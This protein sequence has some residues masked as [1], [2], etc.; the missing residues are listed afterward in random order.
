M[1][2]EKKQTQ[3]GVV[4]LVPELRFPEFQNDGNWVEK[5]LGQIGEPQMC[6]RVFKEQ[7]TSN[8]VNGIPFY[9]IGT[10]GKIP[11]SYI[12]V[13]LYE[14]FKSTYNFPNKGDILISASGT[15]GRLVIYDGKPAYFQDSNIVWLGHSGSEI[16]NELLYYCYSILNWQT[17]DGGVIKRLYNSDLKAISIKFPKN[18]SEQQKIASCL[19]SLDELIAA[20]NEKLEALKD[21][22]KGLM[23]NLFPQEGGT[24]PKLRF[25]EFENDGEWVVKKLGDKRVSS[26]INDKIESNVLTLDNYVSTDNMLPNYSGITKASK[27]ALNSKATKFIKGDIL[28]SN[29][30]P[31]LKKVWKSDRIGGASND[32]IVFRSGTSVTSEF[33]VTLLKNDSFINYVMKSA[34]GVKMPRG[35]KDTIV[36]YPVLLPKHQEQQKIASCLSDVDELISAQT[37]TLEALKT[38]KRGLMHGLFPTTQE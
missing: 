15:I 5:K 25:P 8:V 20:H 36:K 3:T 11:D 1:S 2:K 17:S 33:L 18:K 4:G 10:F 31:Y 34:K 16:L 7:T 24:I 22:K 29:I 28:I 12:T 14:E 13:E 26:I 23:Q 21:H 30:R 19:S 37:Q 6:K 27:L 38:H 32:V 9:K 35:D